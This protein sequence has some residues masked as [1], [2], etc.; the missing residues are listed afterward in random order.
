MWELCADPDPNRS[1][2]R[3]EM[4]TTTREGAGVE[5]SEADAGLEGNSACMSST[6]GNAR[7]TFDV[8]NQSRM[9]KG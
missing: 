8:T 3:D 9:G 2:R 6:M 1:L 4:V 5:G 7:V